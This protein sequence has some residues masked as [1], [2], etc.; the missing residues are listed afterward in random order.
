MM[1]QIST[2]FTIEMIYLWTN[3]GV[4]PI[5]ISLIFFPNSNISRF[6]CLSI[7]PYFI[8]SSLYLFLLYYFF[9]SSFNFYE[10][11]NLYLGLNE[12]K[13][14]FSNEG[15]LI[16]FW[17][18]F[19]SINIFCGAW[20]VNDSQ[21]LMVSKYLVFFPLIITYFIGPVGIFFYWIVRIFYSKSIKIFN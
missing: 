5:W 12:L 20:I 3:L 10:N 19:L 2:Y 21:K 1:D 18:H 14:L 17:I 8:L 4:I 11:F 7:F 9:T 15:F 6:F 16:F 13:E